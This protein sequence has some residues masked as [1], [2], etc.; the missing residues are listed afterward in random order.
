MSVNYLAIL[1]ASVAEFIIGAI[2][3]MPVFGNLWGKIHDFKEMSKDEQ[4]TAQKQM[5]PLLAVQFIITVLTTLVLA[6]LIVL[7]PSYS[8][9]ALAFMLWAGFVVP[10]QI[11]GIIFGGTNPKWMVAKAFVMSGGSILCLMVAAAILKSM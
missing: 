10:T 11:A 5:M 6:K 9:Y 2:W 7:L 4:K 3:Y 1:V 8:V